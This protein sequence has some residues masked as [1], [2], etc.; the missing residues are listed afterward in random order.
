MPR[1]PNAPPPAAPQQP[2]VDRSHEKSGAGVAAAIAAACLV[3]VPITARIEHYVPKAKPDPVGILTGCFGERVDMS[4]LDPSRIY[5]RSEC[6][7]RLRKHLEAEYAPKVAACLPQLT[8]PD[9]KNEFAAMI[10]ASYN[11]GPAGVCSS[12]M[13]RLIK[14]NQWEA[15]RQEYKGFR[16]GSVTPKPVKGAMAVR[17]ITSGPNKGKYFNTFRGLVN[18]R[19][20]FAEVW[21]LP[22]LPPIVRAQLQVCAPVRPAPPPMRLLPQRGVPINPNSSELS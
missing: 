11:G 2:P 17:L 8:A 6:A 21:K 18:R 4:D 15:A 5:T 19:A 1:D 12:A 9:R 13:A 14:A 22:E 20:E 10:D 16:I 7:D 3:C